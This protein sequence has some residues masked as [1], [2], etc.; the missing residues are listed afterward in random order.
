MLLNAFIQSIIKL[1]IVVV[2]AG[3]GVFVGKKVRDMKDA[4]NSEEK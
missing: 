1:A 3:V 4:K 2:F